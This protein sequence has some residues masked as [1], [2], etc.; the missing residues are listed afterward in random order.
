MIFA[1]LILGILVGLV[2]LDEVGAEAARPA[3]LPVKPRQE[4]SPRP[5]SG[6]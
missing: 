5:E 4:P 6:E 3:P 2:V 1:A